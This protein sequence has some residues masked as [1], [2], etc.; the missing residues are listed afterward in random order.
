MYLLFLVSFK[1][2]AL[3][4]CTAFNVLAMATTLLF[5]LTFPFPS[6][7]TTLQII[8][9]PLAWYIFSVLYI[10]SFLPFTSFLLHSLTLSVSRFFIPL[11]IN[12]Q[13]PYPPYHL[14]RNHCNRH[15]IHLVKQQCKWTKRSYSDQKFHPG[16]FEAIENH[17]LDPSNCLILPFSD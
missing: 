7:S 14:S 9:L 1:C 10:L 17:L 2:L 12:L 15:R 13:T 11:E 3:L 4:C 16:S 5:E 6:P 8:V